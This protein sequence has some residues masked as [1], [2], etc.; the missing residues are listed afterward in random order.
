MP[1]PSFTETNRWILGPEDTAVEEIPDELFMDMSG[2]KST[3][4]LARTRYGRAVR[5][6]LPIED[7]LFLLRVWPD[8]R[9]KLFLELSETYKVS[10]VYRFSTSPSRR[11]LL[12]DK[13]FIEFEAGTAEERKRVCL[14][15]YFRDVEEGRSATRGIYRLSLL[16]SM[17]PIFAWKILP[18]EQPIEEAFPVVVDL[19]EVTGLPAEREL[20]ENP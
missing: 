18:M 8:Q 2:G 13:L 3:R 1:R 11:F 7:D 9:V 4:F 6:C 12:T 17:E 20:V 19:P 15:E 16:Y 5:E 14:R 10:F